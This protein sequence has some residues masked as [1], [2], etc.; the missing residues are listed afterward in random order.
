MAEQ[1]L[2]DLAV[3]SDLHLG[4]GILRDSGRY[5]PIEDFYYDDAFRRLLRHLRERYHDDPSRLVLVLNGDCFDF[6]TVTAIPDEEEQEERRF[7]VSKLERRVGL[8]PTPSKSSFKL[9]RIVAGH[10]RFFEA[11]AQAVGVGIRLE[12]LRGN[13]DV[14]LFFTEVKTRLLQHLTGFE[15]GPTPDQ[16]AE[17]VRFHEW[18]YLDPGRLYV[19]HGN[20]YE[21]SN[22]IRYPLRPLLAVRKKPPVEPLLDLPLGAL[23]VRYFYNLVCRHNPHAP[24]IVSFEQYLDFFRYYNPVD[25][26]RVARDHYP[27]F[28]AA[29]DP[30]SKAGSSRGSRQEDDNQDASFAD[31]GRAAGLPDLYASLNALKVHPMAATK[32]ALVREITKPI[33]R[34]VLWIGSV[35]I[36]S[37]YAW[38]LIFNVIQ[39]SILAE[40]VFAKATLLFLFAL[41]TVGGLVWLGGR[42]RRSFGRTR[43]VTI[44]TLAERA[45]RIARIT[46]VRLVLMG[47]THVVDHRCIAD[48][49]AVYANSGTWIAVPNPW[50]RLVP[51]ARRH[52]FL[53]VQGNDV[54]LSRWNDDAERIDPVPL[55]D[56]VDE[57]QPA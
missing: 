54:A 38:V 48:G 51:E 45:D 24:R 18:F 47:H 8:D 17:R 34:R 12:I 37:L 6:L 36:A 10:Q 15:G 33:L 19:E 16:A 26:V 7:E 30:R 49:K 32:L 52:T 3:F 21:A 43:D 46:D 31:L 40:S 53:L 35:A 50:A 55:F 14:E 2:H 41:L 57:R 11:L 25:L 20:Q 22:S 28:R 29:L 4:E 23:F 13:H 56:F 27:F 9:D 5:S 39:A 42:L 1:E 44:E